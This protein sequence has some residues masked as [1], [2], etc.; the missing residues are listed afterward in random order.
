MDKIFLTVPNMPP[1][2]PALQK[3]R[4]AEATPE[5]CPQQQPWA[6]CYCHNTTE[7]LSSS[8]K[9]YVRT[10]PHI[11]QFLLFP[12]KCCD[13]HGKPL[14]PN[15]PPELPPPKAD[16]DWSPF[17]SCASFKLVEFM[18]TDAELSQCRIN[19]LL[20]LWA[21]TL[22]LHGDSPPFS[23]HQNLLMHIDTIQLGTTQW[24]NTLLWYDGPL[25]EMPCHPEWMKAEYNVWHWNP[26]KVIKNIF[27]CKDLDR[28]IDYMAHWEFNGEQQQYRNLM[29][30]NWAWAQSVCPIILS[31]LLP[32]SP[33]TSTGHDC[34]VCFKL[35]FYVHSNYPR[36]GQDN[37]FCSNR[38]KRFSPYIPLSW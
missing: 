1:V 4:W 6:Q 26:C 13:R 20:E 27:A 16:N 18:F 5:L 34:Y 33:P 19:K 11:F 36:V 35:W 9:W 25:L 21:A 29:S 23:N 14:P 37:S 10:R 2:Q 30:G 3:P 22:A 38:S 12:A 31:V 24:E 15:A 28:K 8:F 17:T 32:Y 7:D